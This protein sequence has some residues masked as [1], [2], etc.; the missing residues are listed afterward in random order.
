MSS[1]K[2]TKMDRHLILTKLRE[3]VHDPKYE[4]WKKKALA[5]AIEVAQRQ[6]K[7]R[8]GRSPA[9]KG[10]LQAAPTTFRLQEIWPG[11][12]T[13]LPDL[14]KKHLLAP[15]PNTKALVASSGKVTGMINTYRSEG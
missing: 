5:F 11:L 9:Y 14:Y 8:L 12:S 3:K 4:A 13:I 6:L 10:L 7:T 1:R 2:L 15:E